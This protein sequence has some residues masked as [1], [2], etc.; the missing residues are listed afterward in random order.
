[1]AMDVLDPPNQVLESRRVV[2][3]LVPVSLASGF[4]YFC[5]CGSM[6][7]QASGLLRLLPHLSS[8]TLQPVHSL[9]PPL[10]S[11]G[12]E[13]SKKMAL[14]LRKRQRPLTSL[15]ERTLSPVLHLKE[16]ILT[17]SS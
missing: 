4:P 11:H 1:M 5:S 13:V 7:V 3:Q 15:I 2:Q 6:G 9:L 17:S 12:A 16:F 10:G 8:F 14:R